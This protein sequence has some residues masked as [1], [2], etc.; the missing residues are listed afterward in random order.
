M[1]TNISSKNTVSIFRI[2]YLVP[3]KCSTV[4][5]PKVSTS[6]NSTSSWK[7]NQLADKNMHFSAQFPATLNGAQHSLQQ[8]AARTGVQAAANGRPNRSPAC[9]KWPPEQESSL[10]SNGHTYKVQAAIKEI[11]RFSFRAIRSCDTRH[12]EKYQVYSK[13]E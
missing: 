3:W 7:V 12:G 5:L 1:D 11:Q 8:M 2:M 10:F 9:S 13:A 6:Y 4:F